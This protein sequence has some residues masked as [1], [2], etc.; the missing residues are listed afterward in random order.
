MPLNALVLCRVDRHL[1][2]NCVN[3][4]SSSSDRVK[5]LIRATKISI[6]R[7]P[8]S[9][10]TTALRKERGSN[11]WKSS[12]AGNLCTTNK[13]DFFRLQEHLHNSSLTVVYFFKC[14]FQTSHFILR[15]PHRWRGL[16]FFSMK[17]PIPMPRHVLNPRQLKSSTVTQDI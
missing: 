16:D 2:P 12:I 11:P 10:E 14:V 1:K 8:I 6:S 3:F 17:F 7:S 15:S 9:T 4:S 5:P 13:A